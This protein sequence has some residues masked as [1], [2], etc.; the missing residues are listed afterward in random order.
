MRLECAVLCN[1]AWDKQMQEFY[2]WNANKN[3]CLVQ[4]AWECSSS[5]VLS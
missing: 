2:E 5:T 3:E 4:W 1:L